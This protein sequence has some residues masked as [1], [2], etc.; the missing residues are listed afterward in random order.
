M[1]VPQGGG[2]GSRIGVEVIEISCVVG[3][4]A[5]CYTCYVPPGFQPHAFGNASGTTAPTLRR[6][7]PVRDRAVT[8]CADGGGP[9]PPHPTTH[10]QLRMRVVW[11]LAAPAPQEVSKLLGE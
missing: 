1:V 9:D 3:I 5:L 6:N 8:T 7:G 11:L 10:T 4:R 2:V